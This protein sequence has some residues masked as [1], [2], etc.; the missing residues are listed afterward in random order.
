MRQPIYVNDT[1]DALYKNTETSHQHARRIPKTRI[2][3]ENLDWRLNSNLKER[4]VTKETII[5]VGVLMK[6]I[7]IGICY[8]KSKMYIYSDV[9]FCR[10]D[11]RYVKIRIKFS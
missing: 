10:Y 6:N 1:R 4:H 11:C 3:N 7:S 9:K 5:Y 8:I 2:D